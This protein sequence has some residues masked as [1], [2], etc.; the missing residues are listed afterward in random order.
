MHF[1]CDFPKLCTGLR[2]RHETISN[3]PLIKNSFRHTI[4]LH[5]FTAVICR[6]MPKSG[7]TKTYCFYATP[8]PIL[9]I[10]PTFNPSR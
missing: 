5:T 1:C 2:V 10:F 8:F 6:F 3:Q 7:E 4:R 9:V